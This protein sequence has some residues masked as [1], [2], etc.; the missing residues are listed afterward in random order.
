VTGAFFCFLW[1]RDFWRHRLAGS[2]SLALW[3]F[4]P[5][6]LAHAELVTPDCA[7]ASFGLGAGYFF[8]RWL[9]KPEWPR[10]FAA[11]G[12][13][14]L[15]ELSKMTWI[16]LFGLW[17]ALWL[18]QALTRWHA[19]GGYHDVPSQPQPSRL[20]QLPMLAVILLLGLYCIN[21]GYGFD[22]TLTQLKDF[23]FV[24]RALAGSQYSD[25]GGNRFAGSWLGHL[26]VPL[27]KQYVLGIDAQKTDFED[28]GR[29]SYLHGVWRHGGWWYYYLYG[30]AVKSPHGSQMLVL[31][32]ILTVL[33]R[34]C[35]HDRAN[36]EQPGSAG[37]LEVFTLLAPALTVLFLVSSQTA[38][39][40]HLRYVLPAFGFVFV[41]AGAV[42]YWFEPLRLP[43]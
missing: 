16:V 36:R 39:N 35:V 11:G 25:R 26:P 1:S 23:T 12:L 40:H 18:L 8:W 41:F 37:P 33:T 14:G 7:A 10:A 2:I 30:L 4:D 22:G 28:Y 17:P 20:S 27:P 42:A 15:A 24:S 34:W 32:A 38:F 6:I 9:R 31:V 43:K 21:L 13:L 29:P 19:P 5:N 3:C